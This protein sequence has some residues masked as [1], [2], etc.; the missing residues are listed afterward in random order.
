MRDVA[1]GDCRQVARR[2]ER[3]RFGA[4]R[5]DDQQSARA[6]GRIR[7]SHRAGRGEQRRFGARVR[8]DVVA[9]QRAQRALDRARSPA[10]ALIVVG[11]RDA[12]ERGRQV[13]RLARRELRA[14]ERSAQ[15]RRCRQHGERMPDRKHLRAH[16]VGFRGRELT[17]IGRFRERFGSRFGLQPAAVLARLRHPSFARIAH[18]LQ[19]RLAFTGPERLERGTQVLCRRACHHAL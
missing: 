15:R 12:R 11:T 18:A 3:E 7:S 19:R 5:G 16:R 4:E 9:R 17:T 2:I 6:R 8:G 13:E 1:P 14:R 10:A